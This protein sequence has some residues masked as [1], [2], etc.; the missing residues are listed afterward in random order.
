M[1]VVGMGN[2]RLAYQSLPLGEGGFKIANTLAIL[3]TDEGQPTLKSGISQKQSGNLRFSKESP[4]Q[5]QCAHWGSFPQ[6]KPLGRSRAGASDVRY[7]IIYINITACLISS[8]SPDSIR[9]FTSLRMV[10]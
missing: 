2:Y 6:G 1:R 5:P 8:V 9:C 3:K 10:S 7:T 4:H